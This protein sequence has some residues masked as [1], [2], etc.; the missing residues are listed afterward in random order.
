M[1]V[2]I[3]QTKCTMC[4]TCVAIC[5]EVF[6][7]TDEGTVDVKAEFKGVDITDEALQAKVREAEGSC[8]STAIVVEA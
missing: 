2:S 7:L 6:E 8:P 3:D 4:A 1:K 5:P